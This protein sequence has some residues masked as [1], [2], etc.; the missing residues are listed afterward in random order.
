M[1]IISISAIICSINRGLLFLWIIL[2]LLFVPRVPFFPQCVCFLVLQDDFSPVT[3]PY[4]SQGKESTYIFEL[5]GS[6]LLSKVNLA[7]SV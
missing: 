1:I 6:A 2:S 7:N 5:F 3:R 4:L